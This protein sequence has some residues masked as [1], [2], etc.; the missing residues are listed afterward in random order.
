MEKNILNEVIQERAKNILD[1]LPYVEH[2]LKYLQLS[3]SL[4]AL[5]EVRELEGSRE[6]ISQWEKA[7]STR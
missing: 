5:V 3:V 4:V 7:V 6:G 1:S 2:D